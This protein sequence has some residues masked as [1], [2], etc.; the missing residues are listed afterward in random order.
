MDDG[1]P[2]ASQPGFRPHLMQGWSPDFIPKLANDAR[3]AGLIDRFVSVRGVD[4]LQCARDLARKEGIF[5][6][7]S[8]GATFAG[9][10][11]IART[12]RPG[13]KILTMLPDTGERYL[14]TPLFEDISSDMT[15]E[16]LEIAAS[17]PRYRFDVAA[18]SVTPDIAT[19]EP[20][21]EAVSFVNEVVNDKAQP[22]VMFALEWCEFCWSVRRLFREFGIPYRSIDLDSATYKDNRGS[23]IRVALRQKTG[24]PT[25]PQIFV[26]GE[27]IGGCTETFD[28]FNTGRL[29]KLLD[30]SGVAFSRH[31]SADAYTFLPKWLH[32]R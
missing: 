4:A 6:G 27:H 1:T 25:I 3:S 8:A 24:S 12:A 23:A 18:A 22:V 30:A 15:A 20:T 21:N 16:E 7:I 13:A 32:P 19:E 31:K 2:A 26:G 10:L 5:C 29:Q 17:T 14:S 28:A 11:E 9:A